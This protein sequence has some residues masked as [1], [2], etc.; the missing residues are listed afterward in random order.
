M[1]GVAG[2]R[3]SAKAFVLAPFGFVLS[4]KTVVYAYIIVLNM[5]DS[6]GLVSS[7]RKPDG[8]AAEGEIAYEMPVL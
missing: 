2:C 4:T 7:L 8:L 6:A 3:K 5:Q 1:A